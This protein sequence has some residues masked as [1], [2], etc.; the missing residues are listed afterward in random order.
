MEITETAVLIAFH[1]GVCFLEA[2]D[3]RLLSCVFDGGLNGVVRQIAV[4]GVA[5]D[6]LHR[7]YHDVHGVVTLIQ[8]VSGDRRPFGDRVDVV[9]DS[10]HATIIPVRRG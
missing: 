6:A 7:S 1:R 3:T 9:F 10:H 8:Q 2:P 5:F 4:S